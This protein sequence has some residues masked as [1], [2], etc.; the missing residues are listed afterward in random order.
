MPSGTLMANNHCHEA[1]D[2]MAAAIV[3]PA[4]DDT[5]TIKELMPMPRPRWR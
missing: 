5:A 2:R 1:T 3:G 4:A